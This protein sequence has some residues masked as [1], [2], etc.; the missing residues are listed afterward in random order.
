MIKAPRT[1]D[2]LL[3]IDL[4]NDFLPGG[5]L[6]VPDGDAVIPVLNCYIAAARNANV[7]IFASRDWHPADHCSFK[8][9]GGIWPPHCIAGTPGA[10]F[11]TA[12]DLPLTTEVIS[13]AQARDKDAYS[14][15]EGAGLAERLREQGVGRLLIGGLAT[16]YCVLNTV[17]DAIGNGFEVLLLTDAIRAVDVKPRDGEEAVAEMLRLGARGISLGDL[18]P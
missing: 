10:G 15:F 16:D 4:Q 12:L 7:P 18:N 2:A 17:R 5:A 6:A 14:A 1:G 11:S 9:Q 3:I 13:K 8:P